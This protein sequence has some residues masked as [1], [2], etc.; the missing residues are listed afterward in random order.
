MTPTLVAR[1]CPPRAAW[2]LEQ[3]GVPPLLAR[4]YA[5]RGVRQVQE[6]D[7]Q[8]AQLLPPSSMKGMADP[9]S[10]L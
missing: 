6:L 5:A 3:G 10:P 1:D 7:P 9:S 2:Q 4:L 8:L